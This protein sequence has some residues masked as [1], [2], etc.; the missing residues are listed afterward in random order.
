M[1]TTYILA[2]DVSFEKGN[3]LISFYL[4]TSCFAISFQPWLFNNT[5][6]LT[7]KNYWVM[8]YI[9]YDLH[10]KPLEHKSEG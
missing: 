7:T 10:L 4:S 9:I 5:L 2:L 3:L 8:I 6:Q 1:E